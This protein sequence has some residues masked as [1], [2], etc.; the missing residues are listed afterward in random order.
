MLQALGDWV[1]ESGETLGFVPP[2]APGAKEPTPYTSEPEWASPEPTEDTAE[3]TPSTEEP[4]EAR[5]VAKGASLEQPSVRPH[6]HDHRPS[7]ESARFEPTPNADQG[8]SVPEERRAAHAPRF[9]PP[10]APPVASPVAPPTRTSA[11]APRSG[12]PPSPAQRS[13]RLADAPPARVDDVGTVVARADTATGDRADAPLGR[14]DTTLVAPDAAA[15]VSNATPPTPALAPESQSVTPSSSAPASP[16]PPA[17]DKTE[18]AIIVQRALEALRASGELRSAAPTERE[19]MDRNA[20]ARGAVPVARPEQKPVSDP[21]TASLPT[22][23]A[24]EAQPAVAPTD[25]AP[26]EPATFTRVD[27]RRQGRRPPPRPMAGTAGTAHEAIADPAQRRQAPSPISTSQP[28]A[29]ANTG[30][31]EFTDVGRTSQEWRR[32][33]IEALSPPPP[34]AAHSRQPAPAASAEPSAAPA[35]RE[36]RSTPTQPAQPSRHSVPTARTAEGVRARPADASA[37]RRSTSAEPPAKPVRPHAHPALPNAAS[38]TPIRDAPKAAQAGSRPRDGRPDGNPAAPSASP[39]DR[40]TERPAA[41]ER[42]AAVDTS[43]PRPPDSPPAVPRTTSAATGRTPAQHRVP[44]EL[45]LVSATTP[46]DATSPN[47]GATAAESIAPRSQSLASLPGSVGAHA[48]AGQPAPVSPSLRRFLKPLVGIDPD[49][50]RVHRGDQAARLAA[51]HDADAVAA[52]DEIALG[53]GHDERDPA[54]AGLL[55]HELTHVARSRGHRFVPPIARAAWKPTAHSAVHRPAS[56]RGVDEATAGA[57]PPPDD[58]EMMARVVEARVHDAAARERAVPVATFLESDVD[59][60]EENHPAAEPSRP[61][62]AL[63]GRSA[64]RSKSAQWGSLPAPWEPLPSFLAQDREDSGSSTAEPN[65]S[66]PSAAGAAPTNLVGPA[67]RAPAVQRAAHGDAGSGEQPTRAGS[68]G[69]HD[70]GDGAPDVDA[71]ARQVYDVLRRRLAA[72]R[73]RGA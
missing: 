47:A 11:T 3:V 57:A 64:G 41:R 28:S 54:T 6:P 50:V 12:S 36:Q 49:T 16:S 20:P 42:E 2:L 52:G 5:A 51:A 38:A 14:T 58:E 62:R 61:E 19:Q 55:A 59:R 25:S 8:T 4:D 9:V 68:H 60:D 66:V 45:Q 23:P 32:L 56:V 73:R 53:A 27:E 26:I 21:P 1:E 67:S 70:D 69:A 48:T 34:S 10:V 29:D 7:I 63:A 40:Q 24:A 30:K 72:E 31:F 33:L 18:H 46:A 22:T 35:S 13:T 17:I 65:G 43:P 37:P 39:S 44:D 15:G 71:L